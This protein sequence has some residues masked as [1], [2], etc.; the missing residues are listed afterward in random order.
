MSFGRGSMSHAVLPR[1]AEFI[2]SMLLGM[3]AVGFVFALAI[4][5]SCAFH[6]GCPR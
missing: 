3:L 4:L 2:L 1:W 5:F 6:Y